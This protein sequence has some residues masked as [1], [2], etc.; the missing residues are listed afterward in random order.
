MYGDLSNLG[1]INAYLIIIQLVVAGIIVLLL[2]ETL[3][4]GYG[5]GSGI[6]LFIAVNI[7]ENIIWK[8][9]SP[10]T[11]TNESGNTEYEGAIISTIHLLL[12]RPNKISALQK[13]FYRSSGTNLFNLI[14]TFVVFLVVIYFQG[15]K[16]EIQICHKNDKGNYR[17]YPIKLFYSSNIP[18]ILQSA[19]VSN[20]YFF[21]QILYKRYRNNFIIKLLGQW[22]DVEA[23]H[24][25]PIGGLVYYI[26][27]PNNILEIA[28]DPFHT[29]FY[30]AFILISC[31]LFSKIWIDVSGS[32]VS[33]VAKNLTDQG[34]SIRDSEIL[35]LR[36]CLRDTS[37][38]LRHL[39]ECALER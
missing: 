1:A 14:T 15:F 20:L 9:F 13:A 8:A 16:Y 24:S 21:S 2:D 7:C 23:G 6:S 5:I 10:F 36:T 32:G 4:K 25:V 28:R 19:L 31:A 12:T 39:E 30:I 11:I 18:I 37:L 38:L 29:I 35:R 33:D 34:Y 27:P 17:T 3:Q 22:Q 26:S